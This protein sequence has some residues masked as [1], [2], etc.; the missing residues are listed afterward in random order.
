[1]IQIKQARDCCPAVARAAIAIISCDIYT[2]SL[3][4]T[5]TYSTNDNYHT[6]DISIKDRHLKGVVARKKT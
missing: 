2:T 1:V 3:V 5:A 4:V 6:D